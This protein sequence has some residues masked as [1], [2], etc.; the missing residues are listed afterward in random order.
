MFVSRL[1][2]DHYR[3]WEHCMVDLSDGVNILLGANGLGKTNIV[4]AIE[5]LSTGSSH[6]T[7][8]SLPLVQRGQRSAV[9]R[10]NVSTAPNGDD[11]AAIAAVPAESAGE[12]GTVTYEL[13]IAARGANR[14]RVNGGPSSYMRDVVGRVPSVSFTPDDQRLVAGDPASRRGFLDQAGSLLIPGYA[15]RL[16]SLAKI[17]RQRAA[18]LKQLADAGYADAKAAALS[19]L[20][21]WTGQFIEL[22]VQVSRD[23][24]AIVDRLDGPFRRI[25]AALAGEDESACIVYEPSFDEILDDGDPRPA[26]SAHFQRIYPG[27]VARGQNLIGPHRDD[28]SVLLDGMPAREFASNGEMWTMALALRMALFETI[29]AERGEKPIVILDDVFAQ[30]DESRRAQILD[31]ASRQDQVLITVAAASDIPGTLADGRANVIDVAALKR[32]Q[33]D[34]LT[35]DPAAFG[36][37]AVA[38]PADGTADVVDGDVR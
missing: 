26:I 5:V 22:G 15:M 7:S 18:L 27:E 25:H 19:G 36:L 10:A 13:T 24:R 17:A 4:E 12:P 31:F 14:A 33:D 35:P 20:E 34:W 16:Q 30:L 23:R 32:A 21:V 38:A 29:A 11:G 1:A 3:S 9:I 2:L 37:T 6:R 8:G 28:L